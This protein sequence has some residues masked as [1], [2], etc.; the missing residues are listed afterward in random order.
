[1]TP[2]TIPKLRSNLYI[3]PFIKINSYLLVLQLIETGSHIL[4]ESVLFWKKTSTLN[5]VTTYMLPRY[6]NFKAKF[7]KIELQNLLKYILLQTEESTI[8]PIIKR[9]KVFPFYSFFGISWSKAAT[10]ENRSS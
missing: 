1:M 4:F 5:I 7:S 10:S 9:L 8:L 2:S 6:L 3:Q